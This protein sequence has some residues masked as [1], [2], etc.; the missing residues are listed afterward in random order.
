[1]RDQERSQ[2]SRVTS[3]IRVRDPETDLPNFLPLGAEEIGRT[4]CASIFFLWSPATR[5][6]A[7]HPI[8]QGHLAVAQGVSTPA[9]SGKTAWHGREIPPIV[10]TQVPV[11]PPVKTHKKSVNHSQPDSTRRQTRNSES[12]AIGESTSSRGRTRSSSGCLCKEHQ[13]FKALRRSRSR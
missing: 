13:W 9:R 10:G 2:A 3:L 4:T 1:M 6:F 7:D 8:N 12:P 11:A 5:H